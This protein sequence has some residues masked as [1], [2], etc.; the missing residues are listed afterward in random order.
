MR[1]CVCVCV[2][3]QKANLFAFEACNVNLTVARMILDHP[4]THVAFQISSTQLSI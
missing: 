1:L 4:L 3:K 2:E